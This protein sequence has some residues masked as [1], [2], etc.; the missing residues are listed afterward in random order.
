M[1]NPKLETIKASI[2]GPV[3][4][5]GSDMVPPY[6]VYVNGIQ[7]AKF[8]TDAEASTLHNE[9]R[10]LLPPRPHAVASLST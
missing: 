9:L 6:G 10:Q 5:I 4:T 8:A 1:A 2:E 3:E 7:V